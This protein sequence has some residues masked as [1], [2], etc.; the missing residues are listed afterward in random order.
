MPYFDNLFASN[1][2]SFN[3]NASSS[4]N[5]YNFNNNN[6][7]KARLSGPAFETAVA[8]YAS[9]VLKKKSPPES[10]I[11]SSVGSYVTSI[12]KPAL[13]SKS[14]DND[15]T[16]PNGN[17]NGNGSTRDIQIETIAEYDSLMELLEEH[18][19]MTEEVAKSALQSIANAV[20]TGVFNDDDV[21]QHSTYG[22]MGS[23]NGFSGGRMGR[24]RS[25]SALF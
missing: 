20:L 10:V 7:N 8:S 17:N 12:L 2:G 4:H 22:S 19:N 24:Y 14:G 25:L 23:N 21:R 3:S 6:N 13:E 16:S 15:N 1:T 9:R 5:N 11:D 18:C